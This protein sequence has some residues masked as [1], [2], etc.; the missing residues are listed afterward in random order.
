MKFRN[1]RE[2]RK[3]ARSPISAQ[4]ACRTNIHN[5]NTLRRA[6]TEPGFAVRLGSAPIVS[7]HRQ[8]PSPALPRDAR[9]AVSNA[10]PGNKT[11]SYPCCHQ[12][13]QP[14][15]RAAP[16]IAP[17]QPRIRTPNT[18]PFA[19]SRDRR[20]QSGAG[21]CARPAFGCSHHKSQEQASFISR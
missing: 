13:H 1:W 18:A 7:T 15:A 17:D 16:S 19:R 11:A 6:R 9:Y 5:F 4:E 12:T 21:A 2:H 20:A 14:T 10:R 8:N 3:I